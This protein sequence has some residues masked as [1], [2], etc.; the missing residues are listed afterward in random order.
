MFRIDD[1]DVVDATVHGNAARF[2]N[3]SCDLSIAHTRTKRACGGF[4]LR[5]RVLT[6]SLIT[7]LRHS[8]APR[9]TC[10]HTHTVLFYTH[11][12]DIILFLCT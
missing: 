12:V 6:N 11:C 8:H 3:H 7:H 1:F 4:E 10:T 2:I 5:A 9:T